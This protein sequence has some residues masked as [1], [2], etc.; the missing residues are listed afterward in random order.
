MRED[1]RYMQPLS[2]IVGV[3]ARLIIVSGVRRSTLASTGC[4]NCGRP[5]WA[6]ALNAH[7]FICPIILLQT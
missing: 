7:L 5:A 3:L 1:T 6:D 2:V 4:V